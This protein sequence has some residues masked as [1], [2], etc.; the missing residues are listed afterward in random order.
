M[1]LRDFLHIY[2]Q[3]Q[4]DF[5]KAIGYS[6][7]AIQNYINHV[8]K[9]SEKL[10]KAVELYT[11]GEIT[12]EEMI[13][14]N[15]EGMEERKRKQGNKITPAMRRFLLEEF[16]SHLCKDCNKKLTKLCAKTKKG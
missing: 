14:Y 9:C 11:Q 12:A 13:N 5:A 2:K 7:P 6:V 15:K 1:N 8:T 4:S 10:A 3:K 16:T